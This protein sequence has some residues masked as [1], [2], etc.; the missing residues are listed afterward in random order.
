MA[1]LIEELDPVMQVKVADG[2]MRC[3]AAGLKVVLA[4]T[5]R[6]YEKQADVFR[7]GYSRCDGIK[8]LSMHQAGLA[9][10]IVALDENGNRSWDYA[11]FKDTYH[12]IGNIMRS[13]GFDCGQDWLPLDKVTGFGWDV[14]HYE[15]K[16]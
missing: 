13:L 1:A 2:L 4:E 15:F 9:V 3:K 7:K 16:G 11:K 8:R 6:N 14:P 5:R 10:D 12:G